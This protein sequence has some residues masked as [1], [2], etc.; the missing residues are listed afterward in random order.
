PDPGLA[1]YRPNANGHP[2]EIFALHKHAPYTM[3]FGP[4]GDLYLGIG[5][6]RLNATAVVRINDPLQNPHVVQ[7]LRASPFIGFTG[8]AFADG[9]SSLY[10]MLAMN[11]FSAEV[12]VYP[13]GAHGHARPKR[14]FLLPKNTGASLAIEGDYLYTDIWLTSPYRIVAYPKHASGSPPPA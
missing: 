14:T 1:V 7:R 13:Y 10:T 2:A 5:E 3:T 8:L 4:E 6:T 11:A 12:A 9:A